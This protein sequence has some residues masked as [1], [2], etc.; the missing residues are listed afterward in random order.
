MAR[1]AAML[2]AL[3]ANRLPVHVTPVVQSYLEEM[4]RAL[5]EPM[6]G[7][8][9][10]L[11]DPAQTDRVLDALDSDAGRFDSILHH[12]VNAT[13]VQGGSKINVIPSEVTVDLDGRMLPGFEPD[14]FIA[15]VRAV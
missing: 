3:D 1:L 8:L 13:I 15:E 9:E 10:R 6:R 5:G 12:T 11:A 7:R 14:E 2:T 4:A